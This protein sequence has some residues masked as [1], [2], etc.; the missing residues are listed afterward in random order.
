MGNN[1]HHHTIP[2]FASSK[3]SFWLQL[4]SREASH[5]SH[6]EMEATRCPRRH[7][8]RA[9]R[10]VWV[11]CESSTPRRDPRTGE[12]VRSS[13]RPTKLFLQSHCC[14]ERKQAYLPGLLWSSSQE[15]AT[16]SV[17]A[18]RWARTRNCSRSPNL[19]SNSNESGPPP[20]S[21]R[22][23][24]WEGS[25]RSPPQVPD[26]VHFGTVKGHW[27]Q[28]GYEEPYG[29]RR[30]TGCRPSTHVDFRYLGLTGGE[31]KS[32]TGSAQVCESFCEPVALQI[33]H[34]QTPVACTLKADLST[35]HRL[36][37]SPE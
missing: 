37:T 6:P 5:D 31:E 11:R 23:D 8:R 34:T 17:Q 1:L 2:S 18:I 20:P 19:A 24:H 15:G 36:S 14:S 35:D 10:A 3:S 22:V 4:G 28:D 16:R 12:L 26:T 21:S 27:T 13:R 7:Q 30:R 9:A 25:K 29:I 33:G 32:Y